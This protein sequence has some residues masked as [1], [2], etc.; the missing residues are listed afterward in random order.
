MEQLESGFYSI[1]IFSG[2]EKI[3]SSQILSSHNKPSGLNQ[4]CHY[5]WVKI[6]SIKIVEIH[7]KDSLTRFRGMFFVSFD[8]CLD[9][10]ITTVV[11][12]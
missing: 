11:Y 12:L 9:L 3:D 6:Q 7:L 4:F 5:I 10:C 8:R 1:G 2:K